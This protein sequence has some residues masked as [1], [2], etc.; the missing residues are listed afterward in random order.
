[1]ADFIQGRADPWIDRASW[2]YADYPLERTSGGCRKFTVACGGGF[3]WGAVV[4]Y[5]ALASAPSA[6]T[7]GSAQPKS[8]EGVLVN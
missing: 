5:C 1:M 4:T 8:Q 3:H 2:P 7:V 6:T